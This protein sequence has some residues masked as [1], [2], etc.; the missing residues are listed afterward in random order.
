MKQRYMM[1]VVVQ[2][3]LEG[4]GL[5]AQPIAGNV[6]SSLVVGLVLALFVCLSG[7]VM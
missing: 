4:A 2:P 7:R 6:W 3:M 1:L 5:A